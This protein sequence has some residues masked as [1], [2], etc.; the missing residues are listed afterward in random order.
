MIF[1]I[2]HLKEILI[3]SSDAWSP[4]TTT[5]GEYLEID[6][7]QQDVQ[8]FGIQVQGSTVLD[9]YIITYIVQF[10]LDGQQFYD[11]QQDGET[12]VD[13]LL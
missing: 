10:S 12:K 6:L 2:V 13:Y 4:I 3:N 7:G 1:L 11:I 9:A 8:I 5:P